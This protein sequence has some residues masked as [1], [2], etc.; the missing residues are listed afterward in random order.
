MKSSDYRAQARKILGKNIFSKTWFIS[1]LVGVIVFLISM[2]TDVP[3]VGFVIGLII[4]GPL[5]VGITTYFLKLTKG[6]KADVGDLFYGFMD[7]F[8]ENFI[9]GFMR[10]LFVAL[11]TLLFIIPGIV[12][13]YSYSMA[14]YVKS[15]HPYYSWRDCLDESKKMMKGNKWRLFCLQLSFIWWAILGSLCFGLGL[16]WVDAYM[17]TSIAQFYNDIKNK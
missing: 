17:S 14:F 15:D 7:D 10:W 9:L 4:A 5:N 2:A 8:K 12:K 13:A 6:K 16:F 1:I 11:W 3:L